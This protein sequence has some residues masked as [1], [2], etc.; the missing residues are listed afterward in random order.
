MLQAKGVSDATGYE[1]V[2]AQFVTSPVLK[3]NSDLDFDNDGM[4]KYEVALAD[5]KPDE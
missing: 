4:F 5:V 3:M 2:S 1:I